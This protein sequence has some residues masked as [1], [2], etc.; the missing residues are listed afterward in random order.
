[1]TIASGRFYTKRVRGPA[2]TVGILLGL[3][4][5]LAG[6]GGG[7]DGATASSAAAQRSAAPARPA[8]SQ[9]SCRRELHRFLGS[10]DALRSSLAVGLSYEEYLA[11]VRGVKAA[12]ARID[13]RRLPFG[14]LSLAG[15]PAERALNEYIDAVNSWGDCLA[16]AGCDSETVEPDLQRTWQRASD[17]LAAAQKGLRRIAGG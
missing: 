7:G 1:M 10:M 16:E 8:A 17:H 4:L 9:A 13:A 11:A 15:A 12:Q 2:A 5:A 6:C 14:C 3:A